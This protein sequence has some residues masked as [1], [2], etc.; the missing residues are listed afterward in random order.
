MSRLFFFFIYLGGDR[1]VRYHCVVE[2]PSLLASDHRPRRI[3]LPDTLLEQLGVIYVVHV[4]SR[5][6]RGALQL[7]LLVGGR[8]YPYRDPV[9]TQTQT[10]SL[11]ER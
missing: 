6:R 5:E 11:E 1:G 9:A 10:N 3:G 8:G 7:Q 2:G 4:A